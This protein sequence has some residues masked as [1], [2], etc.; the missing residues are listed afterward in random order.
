MSSANRN[1]E[2]SVFQTE[3]PVNVARLLKAPPVTPLSKGLLRLFA[4]THALGQ[5]GGQWN[6]QLHVLFAQLLAQ[7]AG[8]DVT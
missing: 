2:S 1:S 6:L 8:W 7:Q 4:L 3:S 5:L